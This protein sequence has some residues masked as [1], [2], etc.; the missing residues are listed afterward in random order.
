MAT[1]AT[2]RTGTIPST[3]APAAVSA[4][5][6]SRGL[7][8]PRRSTSTPDT[9]APMR[10][11][12]P[13][14]ALRYPFACSPAL[15][16]DT[17]RMMVSACSPPSRNPTITWIKPRPRIGVSSMVGVVATGVEDASTAEAE[18]VIAA[19]SADVVDATGAVATA[20]A[21]AVAVPADPEAALGVADAPLASAGAVAPAGSADPSLATGSAAGPVRPAMDGGNVHRIA[22]M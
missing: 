5:P 3:A 9:I 20:V 18:D 22:A 10:P 21:D 12:T 14:A 11:P 6:A 8:R 19:G 13:I 1:R 2:P 17:A 4:A 7:L 16:T 15:R